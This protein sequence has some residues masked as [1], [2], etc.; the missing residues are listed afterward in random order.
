MRPGLKEAATVG[1]A[2]RRRNDRSSVEPPA[3]VGREK[4]YGLP[5]E[6][7]HTAPPT[8]RRATCTQQSGAPHDEAAMAPMLRAL[9][10][11]VHDGGEGL[12]AL[13]DLGQP[14]QILH[15]AGGRRRP[16]AQRKQRARQVHRVADG[17]ADGRADILQQPLQRPGL[18]FHVLHAVARRQLGAAGGGGQRVAEAAGA[19]DQAAL[20][21]LR[22]RSRRG[23]APLRR[24]SRAC[25]L[26]AGRPPGGE[27]G[28]DVVDDWS[29]PAAAKRGSSARA[30]VV[31][32]APARWW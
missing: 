31:G 1:V 6:S 13:C 20:Q 22:C 23:P 17:G 16:Q 28:V 32:A 27:V 30:R 21:R 12:P 9:A 18:G 2:L 4:P 26:R 14:A 10:Q 8:D 3:A 5:S 7:R 25:V 24:S 29:A 11:A 15:Q 19:V